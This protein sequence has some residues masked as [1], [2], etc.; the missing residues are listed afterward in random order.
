MNQKKAKSLRRRIFGDNAQ[1]P[2]KYAQAIHP[3]HEPR[4][5]VG[6]RRQYLDAKKAVR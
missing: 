1:R 4:I 3:L 2:T 6:L 5:C